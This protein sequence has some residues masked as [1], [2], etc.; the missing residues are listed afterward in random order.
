MRTIAILILLLLSA[1]TFPDSQGNVLVVTSENA[2]AEL[3]QEPESIVPRVRTVEAPK[4]PV[5][6]VDFLKAGHGDATL[7]RT[8]DGKRILINCGTAA[9]TED[10]RKY[11][12]SQNI[13]SIDILL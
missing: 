10:L 6:E 2:P 1:C 7:I 11:F 8:P 12:R 4:E 5:L 3:Q 9:A 13:S